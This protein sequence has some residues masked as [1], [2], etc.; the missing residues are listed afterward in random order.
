MVTRRVRFP[1][2]ATM[3]KDRFR[4]VYSTNLQKKDPDSWAVWPLVYQDPYRRV[5]AGEWPDMPGNPSGKDGSPNRYNWLGTNQQ[6]FDVF[7][8]V[9][10]GTKSDVCALGDFL[11]GWA[12]AAFL[13][14]VQE[15]I[16]NSDSCALAAGSPT[17]DINR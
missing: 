12:D 6:G 10:D 4:N 16:E 8:V 11:G 17:I 13:D 15:R 9:I 3:R 14:K 7:E 1:I 5:R 2:T